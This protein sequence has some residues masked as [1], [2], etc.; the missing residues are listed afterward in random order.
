MHSLPWGLRNEGETDLQHFIQVHTTP[1]NGFI[2]L[3]CS[4]DYRYFWK[5]QVNL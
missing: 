2:F 5:Q 4:V 1:I 3:D